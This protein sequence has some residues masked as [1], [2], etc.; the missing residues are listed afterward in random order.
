[1]PVTKQPMRYRSMTSSF[2]WRRRWYAVRAK[3][4]FEGWR[5][6]SWHHA[7]QSVL[8]PAP[9]RDL[10]LPVLAASVALVWLAAWGGIKSFGPTAV[11]APT[12]VASVVVVLAWLVLGLGTFLA[13]ARRIRR[14]P[15]FWPPPDAC[16]REPRQSPP[17]LGAGQ[18]QLTPPDSPTD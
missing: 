8:R 7:F 3:T 1:M 17:D 4:G 16:G 5:V 10:R 13:D 14:R 9:A 2:R 6:G 15:P 11:R 18:I 12:E